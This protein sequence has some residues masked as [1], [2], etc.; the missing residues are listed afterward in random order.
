MHIFIFGIKSKN[1]KRKVN[2]LKCKVEQELSKVLAGLR[3]L[4][5]DRF[6]QPMVDK[7]ILIHFAIHEKSKYSKVE[8][9]VPLVI[10]VFLT[11]HEYKVNKSDL[12]QVSNIFYEEF[13]LCSAYSVYAKG[14][15]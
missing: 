13:S 9:L 14:V 3:N 7:V 10:Y 1:L 2:S 4:H 8:T 12:I 15:R 6:T 11:L 5:V